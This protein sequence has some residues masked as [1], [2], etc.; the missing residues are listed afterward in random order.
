VFFLAPVFSGT[1]HD[2]PQGPNIAILNM[3]TIFAQVNCDTIR[4]TL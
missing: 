1:C 3:A 2:G 4:A